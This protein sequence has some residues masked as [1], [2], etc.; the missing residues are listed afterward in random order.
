LRDSLVFDEAEVGAVGAVLAL[1]DA[2]GTPAATH[3]MVS[4]PP[5]ST[6]SARIALKSRS[7]TVTGSVAGAMFQRCSRTRPSS[8]KR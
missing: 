2:D 1:Q 6:R 5:S 7:P 4:S 8:T 3:R